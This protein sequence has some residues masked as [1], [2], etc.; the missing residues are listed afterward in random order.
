MR[1]IV[2][3]PELCQNKKR[4]T[5]KLRFLSCWIPWEFSYKIQRTHFRFCCHLLVHNPKLNRKLLFPLTFSP[6]F[7]FQL[8]YRKNYEDTK[9][10]VHI[11]TDMMNH[12][13]AKKCQYILSDLEYRTYF[14]QWNCS[15]EENDVLHARKAQEILSDVWLSFIYSHKIAWPGRD[16]SRLSSPSPGPAQDTPKIPPGAWG[17]CPNP[18]KLIWTYWIHLFNIIAAF[19]IIFPKYL[20]KYLNMKLMTITLD[21]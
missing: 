2:V 13:L 19:P 17:H 16:P 4:L 21:A 3:L 20:L 5:S 6:F 8:A 12:V 18:S 1:L 14:H 7:A 9:K 11:P 15:P 10:N